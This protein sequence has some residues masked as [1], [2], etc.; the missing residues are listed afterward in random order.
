MP[1][2]DPGSAVCGWVWDVCESGYGVLNSTGVGRY[3][4]KE[5]HG[6]VPV[7]RRVKSGQFCLMVVPKHGLNRRNTW[8]VIVR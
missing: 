8:P 3:F 7:T 5:G 6:L 1:V 2:T 4:T